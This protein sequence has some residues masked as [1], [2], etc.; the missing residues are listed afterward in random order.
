MRNA[1]GSA[2]RPRPRGAPPALADLDR[3]PTVEIVRA[4]VRGHRDVLAAA[5]AA[6]P[7]IAALADAAAARLDARRPG[8][9]R[10]R[11]LGGLARVRR[12]HRVGPD[13]LACPTGRRRARRR[14]PSTR[15][16]RPPRRRPRTTPPPA[17][18][19]SRALAP[20][21]RRRRRRGLGQRAHAVRARRARGRRAPAG[22]LTAR[23]RLRDR[24]RA[25][26]ARAD[27]VVEVP[28]R[29][30]GDRRL[31]AAQGRH[32]AEAGAERVLDRGHGPPRP[33]ARRPDDVDARRQRRS[34]ATAPMRICMAATGCDEPAARA[35]L[36][37]AGDDVALA[38]VMLAARTSTPHAGRARLLAAA[39]GAPA[40]RTRS[41]VV[42]IGLDHFLTTVY[43]PRRE[44]RT[45]RAPGGEQAVAGPRR[46]A[47]AARRAGGRRRDP[48]RAPARVRPRRLAAD[49]AQRRSTSSSARACC[50][51]ATAAA[52]TCPSRRSRCR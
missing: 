1:G 23:D 3:R 48:A 22:A 44:P 11:G 45:A 35:A 32:G 8:R 16:A 42:E 30:R 49:A 47:R 50:A 52:P 7:A 21:R 5:E 13:V 2:R 40:G 10:G 34:C 17:P 39:G 18:P 51:A 38:V 12:R 37:A 31:D 9:L 27:L 4:V 15:P 25:G 19:R 28:G 33:H 41:Q 6:E 20:R 29:A 24:L 14:A 46:A 36:A 43:G 26:G